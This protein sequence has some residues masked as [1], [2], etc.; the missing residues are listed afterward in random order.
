MK[1][2]LV[3]DE[4]WVLLNARGNPADGRRLTFELEDET[5]VI[6]DVT[7]ADYR[8]PEKVKAA[9]IREIE[10]HESLLTFSV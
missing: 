5:K 7:R 2:E 3:L 6:V 9:L 8:N 4:P 10:A 1:A